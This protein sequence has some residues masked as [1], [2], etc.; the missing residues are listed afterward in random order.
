[1][2]APYT[3][4][5][6][7]DA[8]RL[9]RPAPLLVGLSGGLDSTVLLHALSADPQIREQS[10]RAVHVHHGLQPL[11]EDWANHCAEFCGSI[12]VPLAILKVVVDRDSGEGLEAAARKARYAAFESVLR[13]GETLVTAHH[14]DDQAETF[15]LRAL[16]GSGPDGLA[17]M[18][19]WRNFAAGLHWRPLL[20]TPREA[21]LAYANQHGL[22]WLEDPS[23][24]DLRHDRNFLRQRIL[25]LLRERWPQ[26]DAAFTR[27]AVLS[28]DAVE[29][30]GYEDA[31]A[32]A[33]ARTADPRSL[34]VHALLELPA[35]RRA[36]VLRRWVD[37][38]GL[39]PLPGEGIGQIETELLPARADARA[40]FEWRDGVIER[41][42]DLLHAQRRREPLPAEW[43]VEWSGQA[44]LPLPGGD[45]L[46]LQGAASFSSPLRVFAR[47]GGER[48]ALPGRAH[49]HTLKNVLQELGVP[50]WE[51]EVLPLLSNGAGELVAVADLAYSAGFDA[52]LRESGARLHWAR[53]A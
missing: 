24:E 22:A 30:L 23:N 13:E 17:A 52:W 19:P 18:R 40:R 21:L 32:L 5:V 46:Q 51:R 31:L 29:L 16:R 25:P 34:S 3:T 50:P 26:A 10:L 28:A 53:Q 44:P 48:I 9:A 37:E 42:R 7:R 43:S 45:L 2:T 4:A 6:L 11:A 20:E 35:P 14:R 36:R 1:M 8:L 38:L 27:S 33:M 12:N 49:S 15:L 41:W 39:P 47:Q